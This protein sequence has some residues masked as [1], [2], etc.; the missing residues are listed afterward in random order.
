MATTKTPQKTT[1]R[2]TAAKKSAATR[3]ASAKTT[4]AKRSAAGQVS[5][6]KRQTNTTKR[7][8]A[9]K[10][11][12]AT[13]AQR[14]AAADLQ[15]A[16]IQAREMATQPQRWANIPLI[17][18][19]ELTRVRVTDTVQSGVTAGSKVAARVARKISQLV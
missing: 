10:K 2:S 19:A 18:Q 14:S 3:S 8:I 9:A 11:A 12:A 5:A 6:A 15:V 17:A 4:S 16:A 7:S 1:A 13:R